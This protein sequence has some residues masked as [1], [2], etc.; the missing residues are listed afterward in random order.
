MGNYVMTMN[1]YARGVEVNELTKPFVETYIK[2]FG[3]TP[4]YTAD[5][6]S[7]ILH[8]LVPS[9]E[10]VGSLDADK[11]VA[12]LETREYMV[13]SGRIKLEKDKQG[14]PTH[15]LTWGPG[16]LTSL[17]VQWQ[18]GKLVAVWPN[19]WKAAPTAPEITYKGMVPF[20]IP[21]WMKK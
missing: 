17:G 13:P 8:S 7:A 19:K 21:P 20:K 4:T 6:Y 18:D 3:E 9:I 16:Y 2:R 15:D 1:T 10:A 12:H 14:R 11:I 5:T